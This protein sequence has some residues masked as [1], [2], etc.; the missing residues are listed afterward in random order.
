MAIQETVS[1][2]LEALESTSANR[3]HRLLELLRPLSAE[4]LAQVVQAIDLSRLLGALDWRAWG[5][6][7][8]AEFLAMLESAVARLNLET[9]AKLANLLADGPTS[10][11][12]EKVLRALFLSENGPSLTKL[13]LLID[14][15]A[16]GHD[17]LNLLSSDIDAPELRFD[18]IKHFREHAKL[19]KDPG[20]RPLRV[21]SDIDDT[22]Y[23]S[24]KDTRYPKGTV[25]PG[26]LELFGKLSEEPP[27]FLT[28]RPELLSSLAEK[29]THLQLRRYG[30][31]HPT[32]L[33]GTLPGLMG[34]RR[35]AE[36][37]A[38]TLTSYSEIYPEFRF[39]FFGDSG[40]GDMALAELLL[41]AE[42]SVIERA[43]IHKL[44]DGHQGSSHGRIHLY[45][46]YAEAAELLHELDYLRAEARDEIV[47]AVRGPKA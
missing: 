40:Q 19:P 37:K 5:T 13:K 24:L 1:A 32:V 45:Q 39:V 33:S 8:R 41:T 22:L 2:V 26:V 38:R 3:K 42:P 7:S 16:T 27:V 14:G 31:E 35:M 6:G 11:R 17:L 47:Q 36:Q 30:L 25:Y 20:Q 18:I 4:Q 23:C 28:A 43:F 46:D 10:F 21:I 15:C 9:K 12:E 34:H 29:L 44:S